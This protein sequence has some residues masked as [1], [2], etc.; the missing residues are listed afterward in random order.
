M[1]LIVNQETIPDAL[2]GQEIER[3][4][5]QYYRVMQ[6]EAQ[7]ASPEELERQLHEWARE[8]IVEHVLLRQA[9]LKDPEPIDPTAMEQAIEAIKQQYGGQEQFDKCMKTS[10]ANLDALRADIEARLKTERL[11]AGL[12]ARVKPPKQKEIAD[13]YRMHRGQFETP[14]RFHARHVVK[15]TGERAPTPIGDDEA[16]A[17]I[18]QA[19][20]ELEAGADFAEIADR[21]SDCKGNGGDLGWFPRGEMVE[22][23]ERVVF[24]LKPGERSEI[25]RTEF[26]YH[27]AELLEHEPARTL[28]LFEVKDRIAEELSA[29]ARRKAIERFI[30][31]LKQGAEVV[32]IEPEPE[33]SPAPGETTTDA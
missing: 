14:E 16:R 32:Y 5:P 26:G 33:P 31:K 25:F 20:G 15:H 10:P 24:A 17:A 6:A 27:I 2:I 12:T 8:N 4:R 7:Q 1:P 3:L 29:E 21:L 18:E 22:S 30:D 13:Y 11:I 19:R 23:F 9:G 28:P